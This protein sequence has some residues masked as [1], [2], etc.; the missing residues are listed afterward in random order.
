[1]VKIHDR[2]LNDQNRHLCC[3]LTVGE[4]ISS[5]GK[6]SLWEERKGGSADVVI[7]HYISAVEIDPKR[8][9]DKEMIFKI[10]CD[11]G[12]S[13]HY[14]ISRR[15]QVIRLVPEE[16]KAW[17][18]GGSVMPEPD[19]RVWVN[20]FSIGIELMATESSGFTQSQY[21]SLCELCFE[22]EKRHKREFVYLGH[23]H[24]SGAEAVRLGLRKD[25][26]RD[27]GP[28]FDWHLFNSNLEELRSRHCAYLR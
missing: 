17:H 8:S 25:V 24:V 10:F 4:R 2:L 14:L 7:I 15:G 26:K 21:R 22:I 18:C 19:R 11:L 5:A 16:K 6:K 9:Y 20:D 23:E 28:E 12:V 1:M 27:P 13:S 3:G